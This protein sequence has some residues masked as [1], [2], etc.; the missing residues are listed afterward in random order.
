MFANGR[1]LSNPFDEET[2]MAL[3]AT[4]GLCAGLGWCPLYRRLDERVRTC[5]S[6]PKRMLMVK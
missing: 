4:S 2:F 6:L 5:E 3:A 1:L